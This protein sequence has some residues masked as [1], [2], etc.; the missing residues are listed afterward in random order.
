MNAEQTLELPTTV[1]R[2]THPPLCSTDL[3]CPVSVL[4]CCDQSPYKVLA[5]LAITALKEWINH[6]ETDYLKHKP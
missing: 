1:E 5:G 2:K 4:F 3:L 6:A